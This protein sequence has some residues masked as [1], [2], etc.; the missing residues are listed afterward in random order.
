MNCVPG[1]FLCLDS[2][3]G[4]SST[5]RLASRMASSSQPAMAAADLNPGL[6]ML[7]FIV[8]EGD[9]LGGFCASFGLFSSSAAIPAVLLAQGSVGDEE[10]SLS[11]S[12]SQRKTNGRDFEM[13]IVLYI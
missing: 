12:V 6:R 2:L 7:S 13:G 3:T 8:A 5:T 9:L 11:H 4:V 10:N 1:R